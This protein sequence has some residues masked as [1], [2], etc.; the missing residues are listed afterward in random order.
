MKTIQ[1]LVVEDER[2]VADDIKMS[3]Q[4]L[5]YLVS[6]MTSSGEE[7][8]KKAEE[9]HPDLVLMDIVL[10]G[11]MDGVESASIIRYRFDIPVVY[12]TAYSDKK[13]LE[14]AKVT[15]PFGY[16]LKPFKD[17]DLYTTIEMA[18]YTHKM[19]NMLKESDERFHRLIENA[20][21]AVYI[22]A[23][24]GFQYAN[25]AFE[26]LTG[27]K[28][29]ELRNSKFNF[30]NI[31]HPDDKKL[32]MEKTKKGGKEEQ[33]SYEFRIISKDGEERIVE[34]NSVSIG[35][36][37]EAKEMGI[38][39]D[40][41]VRRMAEEELKKSIERLQKTFEDTINALVS[42]LERRDPYTAGHQKRVTNLAC[43]IAKEMGL[44]KK[45]TNGLRFA[46]LIHDVGKIQ[47]PTEILIKPDNLSDIEFV[48]IKMH[49][50]VGYE[51]VE[52]IEF[53]YPVAQVILQHH[54]RMDGSGYPAGL[55]GKD[56]LLEARI[57]AVADV[58][59]AMSSHRPYRPALGTD[60]AME[61]ISQNKGVLYD[62]KVVDA[63]LK[64]SSKNNVKL[65]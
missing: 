13:T 8:V 12:L 35:K 27:W 28:K 29:E 46:G 6:G 49:P 31:V 44:S 25:P 33:S 26:K 2:I 32:V 45:Q 23:P 56:I 20:H 1:I 42:A 19:G 17:R 41:T 40:I 60:K 36:K 59:E 38:I 9:I 3:L 51:I 57:L 62:P 24:Y 48:M 52:A 30:W 7:A 65:V 18:L 58:V 53:P 37:K 54:E 47:I 63:C 16:I 64:V 34:A 5:G 55:S 39:R 22:I 43:A 21:D 15:E 14:R 11:K 50:Q 4:R 61:E 10:E